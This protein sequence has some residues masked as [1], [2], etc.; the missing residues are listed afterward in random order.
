MKSDP[1]I[2]IVSFQ[3]SLLEIHCQYGME[4]AELTITSGHPVFLEI[5]AQQTV[6]INMDALSLV[7]TQGRLQPA[8]YW[9]QQLIETV[10]KNFQLTF[11]AKE[12]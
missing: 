7:D 10:K 3:E 4:P 6:K 11:E 5:F 8:S 1:F 9:Q 2:L 12:L